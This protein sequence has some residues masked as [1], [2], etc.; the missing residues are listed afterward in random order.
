MQGSV[1]ILQAFFLKSKTKEPSRRSHLFSTSHYDIENPDNVSK[2]FF[3][4]VLKFV[5]HPSISLK[6]SH[7]W[8][9]RRV[10]VFTYVKFLHGSLY[11]HYYTICKTN[12]FWK[13]V[14]FYWVRRWIHR[15]H[16]LPPCPP[17]VPL[18]PWTQT[19]GH[20]TSSP[21]QFGIIFWH[22]LLYVQTP[23]NIR[24]NS[25]SSV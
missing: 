16:P 19:H 13:R 8:L 10:C 25:I 24:S 9:A 3:C 2:A 4:C 15:V 18:P 21:A 5:S 11:R 7:F 12:L 23:E 17:R 20:V 1:E 6:C 14:H 22:K